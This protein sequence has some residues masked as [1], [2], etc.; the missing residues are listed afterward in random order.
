MDMSKQ[1][2]DTTC[3]ETDW[4][5]CRR[6]RPRAEHY[7]NGGIR[8]ARE[9]GQYERGHASCGA[10]RSGGWAWCCWRPALS[11]WRPSRIRGA[12]SWPPGALRRWRPCHGPASSTWRSI[13]LPRR[14]AGPRTAPACAGSRAGRPARRMPRPA[15]ACVRAV[16]A[17]R[18]RCRRIAIGRTPSTPPR[19]HVVPRRRPCGARAW[20]P[21]GG[22]PIEAS[23]VPGAAGAVPAAAP[24]RGSE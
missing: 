17:C 9:G 18:A 12:R 8:P 19:R 21:C 22:F 3:S 14:A 7:G 20:T 15:A 1:P 16:R 6:G 13:A 4:V 11:R 10:R 2:D 5:R 23:C 24:G